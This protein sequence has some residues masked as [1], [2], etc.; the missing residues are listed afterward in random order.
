M[1][2]AGQA[3]LAVVR[4]GQLA[5]DIAA[6][7]GSSLSAP[8]SPLFKA[9]FVY[10]ESSD[11]RSVARATDLASLQGKVRGRRPGRNRIFRYVWKNMEG[12]EGI[13]NGRA[14]MASSLA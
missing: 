12:K 6:P 2:W 5:L 14:N 9:S 7:E 10:G 11:A 1:N 3:Q 8:L 4:L 13:R